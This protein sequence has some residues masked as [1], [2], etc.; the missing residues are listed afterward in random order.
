MIPYL[1]SLILLISLPCAAATVYKSVDERGRISFSDKPPAEDT[2]V[3]ILEYAAP[4]P[5]PSA[6]NSAS[7]TEMRET[8]DRMA[9]DRRQREI[10]RAEL[11][12]LRN[13]RQYVVVQQQES[14][15]YPLYGGRRPHRPGLRPPLQRPPPQLPQNRGSVVGNYPAKLIRQH[16]GSAAARAFN[17]PPS[18][19]YRR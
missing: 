17:A 8:T 15:Y 1:T 9:T 12:A 13:D 10:H 7:L 6:G 14:Y 3:E 11:R 18:Y 5:G 4:A 16:Y 19:P 2:L